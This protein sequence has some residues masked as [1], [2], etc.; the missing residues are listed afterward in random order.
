L[1]KT[2]FKYLPLSSNSTPP[3]VLKVKFKNS[4]KRR[5]FK[6]ASQGRQSSCPSHL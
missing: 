5:Y 1:I 2:H 3:H 6:E 4:N